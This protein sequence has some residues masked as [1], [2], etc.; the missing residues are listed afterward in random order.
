M[1]QLSKTFVIAI[2]FA[3]TFGTVSPAFSAS[4]QFEAP[5]QFLESSQLKHIGKFD[6]DSFPD[7]L[8]VYQ[9]KIS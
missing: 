5:I 1:K 9:N 6:G 2:A 3:L 4:P 8:L 7:L